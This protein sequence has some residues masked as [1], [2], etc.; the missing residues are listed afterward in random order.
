MSA[1]SSV[2]RVSEALKRAHAT[3]DTVNAFISID[4]ERAL[5]RAAQ[6]DRRIEAG[7]DVGPLAGVPVALKDL[8]D[9]EG[10]VTTNGS[11]FYAEVAESTAPCVSRLERAGAVIIGR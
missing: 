3:Q 9:H 1:G 10:R 2:E 11:S 6:I 8:I 5:Q 4:D 7:E